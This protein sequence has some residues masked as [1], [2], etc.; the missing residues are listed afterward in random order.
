MPFAAG[1]ED[2]IR[3]SEDAALCSYEVAP[4]AVVDG[5]HAFGL[6]FDVRPFF[7]V[8]LDGFRRV[9]TGVTLHSDGDFIFSKV[10][11]AWLTDGEGTSDQD[12]QD[13]KE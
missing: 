9:V 6:A 13:S 3:V 4:R 11:N 5:A 2:A 1:K 7:R 10:V 12:E 8:R